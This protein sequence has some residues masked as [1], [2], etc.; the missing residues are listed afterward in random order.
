MADRTCSVDGCDNPAR[1]RGFCVM[2]LYRWKRYG[3]PGPAGKLI[4]PANPGAICA[5]DGCTNKV[6]AR[7]MCGKH[8]Q[9]DRAVRN[10]AAQCRRKG[11]TLLAVLDGLC[12][13]HYDRRRRMDDEKELRDS[14][15]CSVEGCDRPYDAGG[16][17]QLHYYRKLKTGDPGPAGLLR[18]ANGTGY[19][20]NGYRYFKRPDGSHVAEHRLVM[21]E[22]LGRYLW[23]WENVHHKNG[24]R[25]DNRPGNLELWIRPQPVGQRVED[26]VRFVVEHYPAEAGRALQGGSSEHVR[27]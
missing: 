1:S 16:F 19:I 10:G 21:E 11:C 2:H 9:R 23:P 5:V 24:R 3:D 14:R 7:R 18:G 26:L 8:Y 22:V 13:P 20:S 15:R 27:A 6:Q 4:Q 12:K 17:C 25:M